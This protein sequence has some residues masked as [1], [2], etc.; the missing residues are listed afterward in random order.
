[1][2]RF[3]I[4]IGHRSRPFLLIFG[5]RERNAYVDLADG[6]VDAHFGF[7]R[8][9]FGV[10]N[11][12]RWRIEGPWLWITAIGVRRGIRAGDLTFAGNHR[13]GVRLDF[14]VP[15]KRSIFNIPR[16]YVTVADPEGF[17]AALTDRGVPGEDVRTSQ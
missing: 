13:A 3:P 17:T 1:M 16:F 9:R 15:L 12:E 7:F 4:R 11:V 5:V 14:R 2:A 10:D 6:E 8:L